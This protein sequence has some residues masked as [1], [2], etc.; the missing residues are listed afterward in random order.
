MTE[1]KFACPVCGQHIT[2]DASKSG[3][4][5]ECP[6]CFQKII[7]PAAPTAAGSKLILT[8][9]QAQ[10]RPVPQAGAMAE[11]VARPSAGRFPVAIIVVLVCVAGAVFAFREILFDGSSPS[12][13]AA[14]AGNN[15]NWTLNLAGVAIPDAP[16]SGRINGRSLTLQRAILRGGTLELRQGP[17]LPPDVGLTINLFAR[18]GEELAGQFINIEADR[19]NAP[20]AV[21]RFKNDEGQFVTQPFFQ[22]YALRLE[23]GQATNTQMP[24]RIYFCA[25]D[26]AKSWMAGTFEAEIRKPLPPRAHPPGPP[27]RRH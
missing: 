26:V 4:R 19:T 18:Q 6:T 17:D 5:L 12:S 22:G 24:G 10:P 25:P 16:V 11:A 15:A 2:C 7:V 14:N 23:F 3:R 9:A 13:S 27:G 8:A 1:F 20:R 21:L